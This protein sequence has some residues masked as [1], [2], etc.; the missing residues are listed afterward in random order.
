GQR[1]EAA[2]GAEGG[3]GGSGGSGGGRGRFARYGWG[4]DY[5]KVM[6]KRLHALAD[7]L[8][9]RWP[10]AVCKC[11]V[12]TAPILERE[13]AARAGL[14]WVGKHTLLIHPRLGSYMLL[15]AIVTT[16]EI[17]PT[18]RVR[19]ADLPESDTAAYTASPGA[20]G[21]GA[22]AEASRS[23]QRTL[24]TLPPLPG[25]DHC[26]TC[27]RCI[28]ACPTQCIENPAETGRR[29][30]DATRCISYLTLE[31]RGPIEAS[32]HEAMGDWVAGCDVCQE[33]CPFNVR[34]EGTEGKVERRNVPD[35]M[36]PRYA[37]R[38]ALV[39]GVPLIEML[40]WTEE[41]RRAA[42]QSSAFKRIKLDMLKRNALI[43]A[44]NALR[45]RE[46]AALREREDAALRER[47]AAL[48]ADEGE[49]ELVRETARQVLAGL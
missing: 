38:P 48:A 4:D 19:C 31:H 3:S 10:E 42:F 45:E 18:R 43:A 8:R 12:D 32:L 36:H 6:K 25:A 16:L 46:D 28:D 33:V 35:V 5:H 11:T 2:E 29:S 26:G 15:G 7:A 27:T 1:R 40:G 9:Q 14:G 49:A 34:H 30:V 24:R 13:H 22:G 37:P 47:V 23:A 17:E 41:D 20:D 44:G 21:A 39:A